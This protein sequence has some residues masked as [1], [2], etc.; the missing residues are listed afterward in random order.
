[1]STSKYAPGTS[2]VATSLSSHESMSKDRNSASIDTVGDVVSSLGYRPLCVCP[3]AT[4]LPFKLQSLFSFTTVIVLRLSLFSSRVKLSAQSGSYTFLF[5]SWAN[6][7]NSTFPALFPC[8][9]IPAEADV[10]VKITFVTYLLSNEVSPIPAMS[11]ATVSKAIFSLEESSSNGICKI[12]WSSSLY[13]GF[14][15]GLLRSLRPSPRIFAPK[16]SSLIAP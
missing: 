10:Y 11:V 7:L 15:F 8:F 13:F 12:V 14:G 4:L 5:F 1:M 6:S 3:S 9:F 16:F 2:A